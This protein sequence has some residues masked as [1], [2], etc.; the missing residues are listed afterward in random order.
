MYIKATVEFD[1][2][3]TAHPKCLFLLNAFGEV[4]YDLLL[5]A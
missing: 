2:P 5:E 1:S 3:P 4:W